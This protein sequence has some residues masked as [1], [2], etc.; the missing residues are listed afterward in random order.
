MWR[1]SQPHDAH[2]D[3]PDPQRP[4]RPAPV[5]QGPRGTRGTHAVGSDPQRLAAARRQALSRGCDGADP[6]S[7]GR[8][9]AARLRADWCRA[10]PTLM[11]AV[12]AS[13]VTELIFGRPAGDVVSEH[14]ASHGFALH[15]P[16]LVDVEVLSALRR[17]SSGE[18]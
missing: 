17:L 9:R 10:R 15:A 8:R 16:H 1:A 5:A 14:L 3:D 13:S 6:G 12:D 18:A 11:L 7:F 4:G 2:E